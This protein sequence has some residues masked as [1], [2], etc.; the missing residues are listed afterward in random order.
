MN[1]TNT[2]ANSNMGMIFSDILALTSA[3]SVSLL[4]WGQD[5]QKGLICD[6]SVLIL[7]FALIFLLASKGQYLYNVTLF[8]YLDRIYKK[9]TKAFLVAAMG[10][11]L[12]KVFIMEPYEGMQFYITFLVLAYVSV[13]LK[14]FLYRGFSGKNKLLKYP[15][16]AFVGRGDSYT[17]FFY[18]VN[19]TSIQ[20][21]RVGYI[22]K[23]RKEYESAEQGVYIGCLDELEDVIKKYNL[24]QI[25][26]I[27]ETAGEI[28]LAQQYIDL[29]TD[30][31]V[32][33]RL[34]VDFYESKN[35]NS[36][37]SSVGTYPVIAYH[38]ISLNA[39][40]QVL[41]RS[42]D[43]LAGLAGLILFSP[44]MI[45]TAI[46][47]KLDSPGPVIFKQKRLG[48]NG[49]EFNIY[50]FRSMYI[51][52][53]ARKA[54]LMKKNEIQGE[55]GCMFKMKNDPR[56][57]RVGRFI[58]K[59]SIDEFPQFFNI[60]KGDMS[61]VGTRPPTMDEVEKYKR[62]QWRRISIKPGLTGMWQVNGR[63]NICS[64]EEVV[65]MDVFY[66][67]NWSLIL[68]IKIILKT[69]QVLINS[70]GAY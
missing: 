18:F 23:S 46:A 11:L 33:L 9:V 47:I 49:R 44:F 22:A 63:S 36:Y 69:M 10:T 6:L 31:G 28:S 21:E 53:E 57:T 65:K 66:I 54:E 68:D 19:K 61:L 59:Y 60:L 20:F 70:K 24:D 5:I 25:Y 62:E 7:I 12:I 35:A 42:I 27:Q 17:K 29:C 67:D 56:V 40:E 45:V 1:R 14:I 55:S 38:T 48:Q 37:V 64:F 34:I 52:A 43:I 3:F 32:T 16:T 30:M 41:K 8:Y 50:K 51:D 13:C 58:R 4:T 39:Y 26:F 15:R 2:G